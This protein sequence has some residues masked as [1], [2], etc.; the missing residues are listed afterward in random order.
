MHRVSEGKQGKISVLDLVKDAEINKN[1]FYYHFASRQSIAYWIIRDDIAR[2]ITD[3][4]DSER[5]VYVDANAFIDDKDAFEDLPYYVRERTG[6]RTLEQGKFLKFLVLRLR[7]NQRF[8]RVLLGDAAPEGVRAYL[9]RL[10]LPAM[11]EDVDIIAGGRYL[12]PETRAFLAG[13]LLNINFGII[14]DLVSEPELP[15]KL[16]DDA[17]NPFWNMAAEGLSALLHNHP[18]AGGGLSASTLLDK[19][20]MLLRPRP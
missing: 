19:G 6:P 16:L 9:K 11:E 4:F 1:T 12:S 10:Y 15:E 18:I 2:V 20:V 17:E 3:N 8:Y 14:K 7:E 13:V 5:F